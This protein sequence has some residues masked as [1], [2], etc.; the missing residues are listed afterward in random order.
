[1]VFFIFVD[2][3]IKQFSLIIIIFQSIDV[4][5][6]THE[7][8]EIATKNNNEKVRVSIAK[9]LDVCI[10]INIACTREYTTTNRVHFRNT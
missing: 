6:K 2:T 5:N 9:D 10:R 1:M 7:Q 3:Q 4:S 8:L